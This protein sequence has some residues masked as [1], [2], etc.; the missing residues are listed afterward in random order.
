LVFQSFTQRII[1]INN[2]NFL[3]GGHGVSFTGLRMQGLVLECSMPV[4]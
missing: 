1:I 4:S 3:G 2:N